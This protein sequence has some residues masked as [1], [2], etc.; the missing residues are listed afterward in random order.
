MSTISSQLR[1]LRKQINIPYRIKFVDK[2]IREEEF[3][4]K[5]IYV[6]IWI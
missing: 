2:V 3:E 5:I 4:D 1:K 6:H